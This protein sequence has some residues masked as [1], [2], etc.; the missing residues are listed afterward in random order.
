MNH[1]VDIEILLALDDEERES[2]NNL[3]EETGG[4]LTILCHNNE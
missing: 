4:T 3:L 2:L 1:A